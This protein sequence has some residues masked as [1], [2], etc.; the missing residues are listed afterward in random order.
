VPEP[1]VTP[2]S[3]ARDLLADRADAELMR[4][5]HADQPEALEAIVRGAFEPLVQFV[6]A[7]VRSRDS[8]EDVVQSVLI[9]VWEDRARLPVNVRLRAYLYSAVRNRA[10]DVLKHERIAARFRDAE[11]RDA[12][13]SL[14]ESA[15]AAIDFDRERLL[16]ALASLTDRQRDAVRL[17]YQAQLTVTEVAATLGVSTRGTERLLQRAV[18]VLRAALGDG[19]RPA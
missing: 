19:D 6:V 18:A 2:P 7:Y 1:H 4:G 14:P 17:R 12:A 8:A 10:L 3:A 15:S 16:A 11:Q 13:I 5:L 9:H